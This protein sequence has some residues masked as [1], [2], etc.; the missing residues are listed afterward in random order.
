MSHDTGSTAGA[1]AG[2]AP[3]T[4][5]VATVQTSAADAAAVA[6]YTNNF[7]VRVLMVRL[8]STTTKAG[9]EGTKT[10]RHEANSCTKSLRAFVSSWPAFRGR[11]S[12][13]RYRDPAVVVVRCDTHDGCANAPLPAVSH[14]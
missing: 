12:C 4:G 8:P 6:V 7:G 11:V 1:A 10:R 9:H 3:V 2:V 5:V 13:L 14:T